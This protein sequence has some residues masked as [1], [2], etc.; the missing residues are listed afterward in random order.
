MRRPCPERCNI[1]LL[2]TGGRE[3]AIASKLRQSPRLGTLW[4]Q[5]N[6]N[7]GILALGTPCPEPISMREIFRLNRWCDRERIDL[8]VIGPEGPLAEG[9]ADALAEGERLVFGPT[10]EASRLEWDKAYAKTMMRAAAIPTA[11]GRAF[12]SLESAL[13]YASVRDEP[14]VV[15]ASG[16]AAG[17]GVA[18]CETQAEAIHAIKEA[19][20]RRAF[21][22][23]GASIVIEERLEGRELSVMALVDGR[24]IWVLDPCEDHKRVGE[25]DTGPNT[26]GMGAYCPVPGIDETILKTVE[27]DV[28]VPIVDALRREEI[29]YRGVLYAGLMLTPGGPKV[30]E[31]NCRF[32]D[33]ETE[34]LL[35]RLQGDLVEILWATAA[36]CLDEIDLSF[37]P[38]S[39]VCTVVCSE[40]YP[41]PVETG[42]PIAGIA[43][44]KAAAG[45]GEQVVVFHAGTRPD[46]S[47]GPAGVATAGGR[48]LAVTA[49]AADL[50]RARDLSREAARRIRFDGAFFRSDLAAAALG[51]R[52]AVPRDAARDAAAL[53]R[54]RG[55]AAPAG[56]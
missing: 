13:A 36:G 4:V 21:G 40:G 45:T 50:R 41:G 18:V 54:T 48:V 17:N 16:L 33:P 20:E 49:L 26:G 34:P 44:A 42:L 10:K 2:G 11:E 15:K 56:G 30:L 32:G 12:T 29:E 28:L 1:L 55:E 6:A 7:A 24:T 27:R 9:F 38:R 14:C 43:E 31:F 47:Q 25:H 19:M 52:P 39:A 46:P 53:R 35:A 5:P 8:V 3:H 51:E 23:A 37:D 22:D